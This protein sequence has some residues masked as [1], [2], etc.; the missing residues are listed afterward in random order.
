MEAQ[1]VQGW[2][3][4]FPNG[5]RPRTPL[6]PGG[7]NP[8]FK[9]ILD[10]P[11]LYTPFHRVRSRFK[12]YLPRPTKLRFQFTVRGFQKCDV[13]FVHYSLFESYSLSG[14]KVSSGTSILVQC[15]KSKQNSVEPWFKNHAAIRTPALSS[16]REFLND[17]EQMA[18]DYR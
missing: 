7:V 13:A 2:I 1:S 9:K 11:L 14:P 6:G 4:G 17:V 12:R 10:P 5:A 15:P 16:F 18:T 8:L 3:Q